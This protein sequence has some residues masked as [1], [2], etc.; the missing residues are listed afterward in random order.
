M[1]EYAIAI[2][3]ISLSAL[4]SG[5]TLGYFTLST[6]T[7]RRQ[8]K[9][10]NVAAVRILPVREK[11]NQLLTT[12]LLGNVAVNSVLSVY[13]S[14]IATGVVAAVAA[15]TLIFLLGEIIPQAVLS[16]HAMRFGSFAA[17]GVRVFMFLLSPITLPI[18]WTLDKVLGAEMHT[19]YSKHEL[20][21]IVSEHEDSEHSPIDED[22]E[23]IIH[24]ALQFS[25][26]TVR[27]VMTP[28]ADV[29]MFEK[30][31]RLND[32]FF[33]EVIDHGHSRFPIYSGNREKIMGIL[34]TKD[35]LTE[36]D[37]IA[38]KD[39]TEALEEKFFTVRPNEMLD[40][41]LARMLKKKLHMGIVVN[42]QK[43]FIGVI[44]LEDIIEEIIQQ[45][46]QDEDDDEDED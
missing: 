2:L 6:Q 21:E 37:D 20:M 15:T 31:Q 38:I 17:P 4:F 8:A 7:L 34:F 16:R 44:T 13:L 19:V 32:A 3:L 42:K 5:L 39:T 10:G 26:T 18:A 33:K 14:T 46:I 25:H 29:K 27:E 12:L 1:D 40:V 43:T 24:G 41:V 35:L 11:G 22:E 23:R 9:F 30:H 28:K 36:E 45:E